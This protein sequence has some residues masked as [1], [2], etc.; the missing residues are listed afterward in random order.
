M[1]H[2]EPKM[3]DF[4]KVGVIV[5]V[6]RYIGKKIKGEVF[7]FREKKILSSNKTFLTNFIF[8]EIKSKYKIP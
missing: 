7:G 8:I 4:L 1:C 3:I 6:K 2:S 5:E